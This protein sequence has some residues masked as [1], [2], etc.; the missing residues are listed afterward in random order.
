[1]QH[2]K[3]NYICVGPTVSINVIKGIKSTQ[4]LNRKSRRR[5]KNI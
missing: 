2:D 5:H 4:I 3:K 1:M